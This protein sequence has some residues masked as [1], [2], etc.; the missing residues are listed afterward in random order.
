MAAQNKGPEKKKKKFL[1][2]I[3]NTFYILLSSKDFVF[4]DFVVG[5]LVEFYVKLQ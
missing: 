5:K 2:H 3:Y 1:N 4:I